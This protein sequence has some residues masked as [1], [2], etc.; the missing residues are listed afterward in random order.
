[1]HF[2]GRKK[3]PRA[4]INETIKVLRR[5]G[6]VLNR[7]IQ[8]QKRH[9]NILKQE[10]KKCV[11]ASDN[12]AAKVYAKNYLSSLKFESRLHSASSH[13]QCLMTEL[14]TQSSLN[15]FTNCIKESSEAM[16]SM[17]VLIK[18]CTSYVC[19]DFFFNC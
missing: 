19:M 1:M 16:K 5:E 6:I 8:T 10:I 2:F 12:A 9:Q 17:N 13:L 4:Q 11:K 14:R 18:V 3:D 7:N 15:N